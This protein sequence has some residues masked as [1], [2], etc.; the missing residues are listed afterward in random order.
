MSDTTG[1]RWLVMPNVCIVRA[2]VDGESSLIR[3][4]EIQLFELVSAQYRSTISPIR[5][6]PVLRGAQTSPVGSVIDARVE[7]HVARCEAFLE[8]VSIEEQFYRRPTPAMSYWKKWK[9]GP[10]T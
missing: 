10:P 7:K 1:S 4:A 5:A 8:G 2:N 9:F 3:R 6:W